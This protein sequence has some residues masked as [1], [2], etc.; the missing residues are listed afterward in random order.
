MKTKV[1]A[2]L[3]VIPL[4]ASCTIRTVELR[5]DIKEF[6]A[7]FSLDYAME[8]YKSAHFESDE[9][10]FY[11]GTNK[12]VEEIKIIDFDYRDENN[13]SY[14]LHKTVFEDDE[15]IS[16][17]IYQL[18]KDD[19]DKYYYGVDDGEEIDETGVKRL[20]TDFFYTKISTDG[21]YHS[22]GQYYGDYLQDSSPILQDYVT[23]DLDQN[24]YIFD[25]EFNNSE[26]EDLKQKIDKQRYEVN[27]IGM[28][29]NNYRY[30]KE[31]GS[32]YQNTISVKRI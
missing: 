31:N 5:S 8:E 21:A 25:Y 23:I 15:E 6:I 13:L 26:T 17:D 32:Y 14:T 22:H 24:L 27:E 3:I 1:F 19:N 20:F 7:S 11:Y 4:L 10:M 18:R 2:T 30:K 28:L 9:I 16:N 12:K 29:V